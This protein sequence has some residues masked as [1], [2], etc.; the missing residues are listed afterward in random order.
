SS[1]VLA[2]LV[3]C[4][5]MM[6]IVS[7]AANLMQDFKTGVCTD[8]LIPMGRNHNN[9]MF[10]IAPFSLQKHME[11]CKGVFN[12]TV[13]PRPNWILTE[14]GGRVSFLPDNIHSH[15]NVPVKMS[16]S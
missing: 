6:S 8:I 11:F 16:S 2:D 9:S 10:P 12:A 13:I 3:V 15:S 14:F 5:V 1:G 4:W 7:T